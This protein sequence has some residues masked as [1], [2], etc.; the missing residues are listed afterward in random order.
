[1]ETEGYLETQR[2][3]EVQNGQIMPPPNEMVAEEP[4]DMLII[5]ISS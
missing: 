4:E 5:V 1:M 2:N 3:R